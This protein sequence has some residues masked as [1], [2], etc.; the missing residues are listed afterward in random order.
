[1]D[2]TKEKKTTVKGLVEEAGNKMNLDLM[3]SVKARSKKRLAKLQEMSSAVHTK[4][5]KGHA[6]I[7]YTQEPEMWI[8]PPIRELTNDKATITYHVYEVENGKK[9]LVENK[10]DVDVGNGRIEKRVISANYIIK[11]LVVETIEFGKPLKTER[12]G[13]E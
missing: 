11:D 2:E 1:M 13:M 7:W 8:T 5:K 3:M 9:K 10:V 6:I 4:I 12:V